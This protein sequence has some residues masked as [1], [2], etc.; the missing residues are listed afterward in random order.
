MIGPRHVLT[1][2]HCLYGEDGWYGSIY[3]SPGQLGK[4][5]GVS[6]TPNRPNGAPRKAK[7][8]YARSRS[9]VSYDYGLVILEDE[10][11]TA[12]LGWFGIHWYNLSSYDN[13]TSYLTGFPLGMVTK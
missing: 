3:F 7:Y 6:G 1:A 12:N 11:R 9:N 8:Y 2:A 10:Q 13:F 4:H 5:D